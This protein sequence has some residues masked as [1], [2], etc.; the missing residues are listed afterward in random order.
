[1]KPSYYRKFPKII[2]GDYFFNPRLD[3]EYF[4]KFTVYSV[5]DGVNH[6]FSIYFPI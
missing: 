4:G 2:L 3:G 6:D 5:S 1:M